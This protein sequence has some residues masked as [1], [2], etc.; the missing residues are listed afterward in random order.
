MV[1]AEIDQVASQVVNAAFK[2]HKQLGPGLLERVYEVCLAYELEKA[3][4]DE[5]LS[6]STKYFASLQKE[7]ERFAAF[8]ENRKFESTEEVKS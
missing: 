7:F 8:V 6:R 3:G 4:G 2:V 1:T 5:D